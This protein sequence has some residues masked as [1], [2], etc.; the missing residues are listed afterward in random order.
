MKG[1]TTMADTVSMALAELV[2]KAEQNGDVDFLRDGVRVL[3]QALM[4]VEVSQHLGAERHERTAERTGQ[5]NGY[6]EREW[7]TRVGTIGLRVPRVRDGSYFPAMLEPR[8]RAEQ[9]IESVN[10]RLVRKG[11]LGVA[12]SEENDRSCLVAPPGEV[13]RQ[14][15][16]ACSGF[17]SDEHDLASAVTGPIPGGLQHVPFRVTPDQWLAGG[18][19]NPG[20]Q[21]H[22]GLFHLGHYVGNCR[23]GLPIDGKD[24]DMTVARLVLAEGD[25]QVDV[26]QSLAGQPAHHV[27]TASGVGTTGADIVL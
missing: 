8:K 12:G 13:G 14:P 18:V 25:R 3:S 26:A 9:V 27:V 10:P 17:A 16:L 6:R 4:E 11:E 20:R 24:L 22:S 7:D 19:G 21:W 5:R 15:G 2:R 23:T 1:T